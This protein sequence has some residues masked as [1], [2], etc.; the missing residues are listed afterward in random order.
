MLRDLQGHEIL[1]LIGGRNRVESAVRFLPSPRDKSLDSPLKIFQM[2]IGQGRMRSG[3][4]KQFADRQRR[5][6]PRRQYPGDRTNAADFRREVGPNFLSRCFIEQDRDVQ[7]LGHAL[8]PAG[9]IY[10]RTEY[11]DFDVIA[12]S[13]FSRHGSTMRDADPHPEIGQRILRIAQT[14]LKRLT[15]SQ[16]GTAS[17]QGSGLR[18]HRPPPK[19]ERGITQKVP[20]PPPP[21]P[22]YSA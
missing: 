7:L 17:I 13:D 21:G 10:D 14:F 15:D 3:W 20:D 2:L 5:R 1:P 8:Q 11:R 19:A 12:G 9:Q 16:G 4:G 18:S 6:Q 22:G